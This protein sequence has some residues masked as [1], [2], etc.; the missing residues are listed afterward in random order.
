[1]CNTVRFN[2]KDILITNKRIHSTKGRVC[3]IEIRSEN[4]SSSVFIFGCP[5]KKLECA[6]KLNHA[7]G[8]S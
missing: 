6:L 3:D 4:L 8:K 1:M 7:F 2:G 5:E